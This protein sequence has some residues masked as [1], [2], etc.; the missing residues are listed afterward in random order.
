[1]HYNNVVGMLIWQPDY[2][3]KKYMGI[4]VYIYVNNFR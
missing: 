2:Y 1:M 4:D 3:F